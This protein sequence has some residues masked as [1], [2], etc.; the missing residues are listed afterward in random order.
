MRHISS[1]PN[2][3]EEYRS[4]VIAEPSSVTGAPVCWRARRVYGPGSGPE[5]RWAVARAGAHTLVVPSVVQLGRV[6][7]VASRRVVDRARSCVRLVFPARFRGCR[8]FLRVRFSWI[9]L[10]DL[11]WRILFCPRPFRRDAAAGSWRRRDHRASRSR[12]ISRVR[13]SP[14]LALLVADPGDA[15]SMRVIRHLSF[16]SR[17]SSLDREIN[18]DPQAA[19][20]PLPLSLPLSL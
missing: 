16:L 19:L 20:C 2:M 13:S 15:G 18:L 14:H 11:P 10:A 3:C 12:A 17:A 9:R 7:R 5:W 4:S 8:V 6:R 1:S